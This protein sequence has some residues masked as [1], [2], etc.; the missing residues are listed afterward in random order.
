VPDQLASSSSTDPNPV[1]P[2]AFVSAVT[3]FEYQPM[4][5]DLGVVQSGG[6]HVDQYFPGL[7]SGG[8]N[9]GAVLELVESAVTG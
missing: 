9:I 1:A 6:R 2:P 3:L 5:V 7:G 4:R 8:V